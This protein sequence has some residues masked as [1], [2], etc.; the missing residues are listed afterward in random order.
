MLRRPPRSTRPDPLLPYSTLFQSELIETGDFSFESGYEAT[1][2]LLSRKLRPTAI[3]AQNDDM[4]V[5]AMSAA[6]ELGF[7]VPADLTVVGF[8]DSEIARVVLP[9]LTT[10]RQPVIDRKSDVEGKSVAVSVDLGG[11]RSIK[12]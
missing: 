11:R 9:R 6:R 1:K 7:D 12:N 5:G 2:R 10:I 4:A 3:L 8:D